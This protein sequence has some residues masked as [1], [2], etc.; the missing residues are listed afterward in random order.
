M[1]V[2]GA[3]GFIGSHLTERLSSAGYRVKAFVHYNSRHSWG[4]LD[5]SRRRDDCDVVAGD[6]CN[7]DS[8]RKVMEG[9][10]V[11]F[12]LAALIGVP[13][14]YDT[15]EAYVET[16]VKGTL[17]VLQAAKDKKVHRVV[18]I[19]TSEVYGTAQRIPISEDH[20]VNPQSP[21][22]A[23]KAAA[24]F[25]A[26]SFYRSF[27]LPIVIVRP[28]N[29]YG[30]RQSTRAVIPTIIT[31]ILSGQNTIQLGS[32]TPLRDFTYVADTVQGMILAAEHAPLGE[33]INIGNSE[34][35]SIQGL[36]ELIASSMHRTIRIACDAQ[37]QRPPKSEV[38]CLSADNAKAKR[39]LQWVPNYSLAQG[40]R[41]TP[42]V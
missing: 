6:I 36:A 23:T 31:Q 28:F 14:S 24:D 35:I 22:A 32:V 27:N 11:V 42:V 40:L 38:L 19:S 9:V 13:Y 29:T 20:P 12:H 26:L 10:D 18:H 4:W 17:N 15:P 7:A 2:T 1:L 25:L 21:Y 34:T 8:V 39:I 3:G 37:R 33:I 41:E 5:A 16:N 30:P